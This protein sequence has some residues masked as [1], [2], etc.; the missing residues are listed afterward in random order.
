MKSRRAPIVF[1][2]FAADCPFIGAERAV[3]CG[4]ATL[5]FGNRFE[6]GR[7]ASSKLFESFFNIACAV[8]HESTMRQN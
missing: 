6:N 1:N 5:A 3:A 7:I 4:E 8:G 2:Q